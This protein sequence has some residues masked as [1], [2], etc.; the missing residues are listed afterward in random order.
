MRMPSPP[1]NST[2]FMET[3]RLPRWWWRRPNLLHAR[4]RGKRGNGPGVVPRLA[5]LHVSGT[6]EIEG[7]PAWAWR[8]NVP[9]TATGHTR[10]EASGMKILVSGTDGYIGVQLGPYRVQRR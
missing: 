10:C 2:T 3:P 4:R 1:Q 6:S 7:A 9:H 8:C 5:G